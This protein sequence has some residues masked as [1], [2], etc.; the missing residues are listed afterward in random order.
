MRTTTIH[1]LWIKSKWSRGYIKA[2]RNHAWMKVLIPRD[3]LHKEI[4]HQIRS[5][6]LPEKEDAKRVFELLTRLEA[7]GELD[8]NAGIE[9]RL[10]FLVANIT[11][12]DTVAALKKQLE[13]VRQ[14]YSRE[15]S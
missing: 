13:I 6:P 7:S 8:M 3:T 4:H 14:F 9:E 1:L 2:L 10:E 15:S 11:T 12:P 5:I